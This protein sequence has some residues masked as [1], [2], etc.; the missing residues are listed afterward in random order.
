MTKDELKTEVWRAIDQRADAVVG[1]GE[2]IRKHPELGF[3]ETKTAA[4]VEETLLGLGLA[5][6][7]GLAMTGVKAVAAGAKGSGRKES[8]RPRPIAFVSGRRRSM[9]YRRS[10]PCGRT[11]KGYARPSSSVRS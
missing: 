7:T 4:L 10:R 5:P 2:R 11:R 1:I 6:Q 9:S 3:K 8:S